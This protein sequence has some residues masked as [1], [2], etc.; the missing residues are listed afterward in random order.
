[1][2]NASVFAED[3]A[4][5]HMKYGV[6]VEGIKEKKTINIVRWFNTESKMLH[7]HFPIH[8]LFFTV[9][10]IHFYTDSSSQST[11]KET[12]TWSSFKFKARKRT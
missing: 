8:I 6:K 2:R 3:G 12:S 10:H 11:I 1:M 4:T 7:I 5:P 9:M